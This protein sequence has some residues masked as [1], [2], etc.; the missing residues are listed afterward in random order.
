MAIEH[1]GFSNVLKKTWKPVQ[2]VYLLF[3]V[4]IGWVFFRADTLTQA[5]DYLN[6][7]INFSNIQTEKFQL[8]QVLSNESFFA[9]AIGFFLAIPVYV[10]AKSYLI[11]IKERMSTKIHV[12]VDIPRVI[13]LSTLLSLCIFKIVSSTYNPFIYFRF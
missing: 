12:F 4:V 6:A 10:W 7:M 11:K 13:Y 3:T 8:F 5:V 9:Y 1:A 2:H